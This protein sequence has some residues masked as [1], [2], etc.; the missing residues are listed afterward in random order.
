MPRQIFS[1]DLSMTSMFK[2]INRIPP[3]ASLS[4][5]AVRV[6]VM[7]AELAARIDRLTDGRLITRVARL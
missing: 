7:K 4:A 5:D 1:T 3:D 2:P 6:T